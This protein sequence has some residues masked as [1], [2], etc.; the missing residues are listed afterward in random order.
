M[1]DL[2]P[3]PTRTQQSGGAIIF[4][5]DHI[6]AASMAEPSSVL[7]LRRQTLVTCSNTVPVL[8]VAYARLLLASRTSAIWKFRIFD[9][10]EARKCMLFLHRDVAEEYHRN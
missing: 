8:A 10:P 1:H 4:C 9:L 5:G 3:L 2:D 6:G 7:L